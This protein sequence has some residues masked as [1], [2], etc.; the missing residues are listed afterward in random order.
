MTFVNRTDAGHQLAEKVDKYLNSISAD[1]KD[2][3]VV[4]L[5]R[6]GVVV[7]LEVARKL[8]CPVDVLVSKK[9][10]Y[11]NKPEL[12]I[13]AVSS[14]GLTVLNSDLPGNRPWKR[15]IEGQ[16]EELLYLTKTIES[17]LYKL[18]GRSRPS[19]DNKIVII[20][21]DGIATGM[22]AASALKTAKQRG[23]RMV[24]LAVPVLS[25]GSQDLLSDYCDALI[26]LSIPDYLVSVSK[27]YIDFRQ[28]PEEFVLDALKESASFVA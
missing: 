6:G 2:L 11:P 4:G 1:R 9:L 24:V 8:G 13:G 28:I 26:C 18:A 17:K 19:F 15:Y 12:A 22:T 10:P 3:L 16:K 27:Q 23:A 25:Q 20:V 21:D 7:A 5:P 14:D